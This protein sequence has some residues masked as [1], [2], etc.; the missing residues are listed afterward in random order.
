[1]EITGTSII[2]YDRGST[3]GNTFTAFNPETGKAVEPGFHSATENELDRAASLADAARI[4]YGNLAGKTR[5]VFLRKIADGIE[6]IGDVLIQRAS[7]ETA[8]PNQRFV[9]ER[10]RTCG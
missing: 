4:P 9:G 3:T 10:A 5:A 6:A 1:M 2:G 7:L 8:L